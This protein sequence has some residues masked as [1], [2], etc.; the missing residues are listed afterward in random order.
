M[1]TSPALSNTANEPNSPYELH[2]LLASRLLEKSPV[3][4]KLLIYLWEHRA[5]DINEY[6]IATEALDRRSGFDPR[7]DAA[8]RVQVARLRQKLKEFYDEEGAEDPWRLFIPL[9]SYQ[10]H[11][12]PAMAGI[13]VP[14]EPTQILSK[15]EERP[16]TSLPTTGRSSFRF[17]LPLVAATV[18]ALPLGWLLGTRWE[19]RQS[20]QSGA[21]RALT[22]SFWSNLLKDGHPTRIVFPNPVFFT[23]VDKDGNTLV[24]RDPSVNS[25]RDLNRSASLAGLETDRG[26]PVLAQDYTVASDTRAVFRLAQYLEPLGTKINPSSSSELPPESA[27]SENLILLG[28]VGT[29]APY[30]SYLDRLRFRIPEHKQYIEDIQPGSKGPMRFETVRESPTRIV[31]PGI[32]ALLPGH[33]PGTFVLI[34]AGYH[35][36]ALISY[37][38]SVSG[39]EDLQKARASHGNPDFFEAVVLSEVNDTNPLHSWVAGFKAFPAGVR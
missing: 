37:L 32:I 12:K 20:M 10:I 4:K 23:W 27:D 14:S 26:K 28:T 15:P 7:T 31:A 16:A 22:S 36:N 21:S 17:L 2:G 11:A 3:L 19:H 5:E 39:L 1:A 9:G 6:V 33:T 8:V 34:L 25:Y 35:T 13:V 38:T 30:Q 29:L 24:V 18:C